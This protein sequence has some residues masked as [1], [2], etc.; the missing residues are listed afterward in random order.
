MRSYFARFSYDRLDDVNF[1]RSGQSLSTEWRGERTGL[2]SGQLT[3]DAHNDSRIFNFTETALHVVVTGLTL[4]RGVTTANNFDPDSDTTF[5]GGALRFGSF[6]ELALTDVVISDSNTYGSHT[7]GGGMYVAG[8]LTMIS[9]AVLNCSTNFHNGDGGGIWVGLDATFDDCEIR[10]NTAGGI[11]SDGGGISASSLVTITNSVIADNSSVD[12]GGGVWSYS[13]VTIIGSTISGNSTTM[14]KTQAGGV[15]GRNVTVVSSTIYGN[16]AFDQGGG[17]IWAYDDV[18]VIGSTVSGNSTG[19]GD[20]SEGGGIWADRDLIIAFSTI[21][22]NSSGGNGGGIRGGRRATSISNS[23]V[24]GNTSVLGTH[25]IIRLSPHS[26]SVLY[27][28]VGDNTGTSLAE[29]Q[30]TDPNG[31]RIGSSTGAGVINPKLGPLADNGGALLTHALLPGSPAIDAGDPAPVDPPIWDVRA[32][33]FER[34]RDGNGDLAVR[35]DMGAFEVQTPF[36]PSADFTGDGVVDGADFLAWQRGFGL[37]GTALPINGDANGDLVVDGADLAFWCETFESPEEED[38]DDA[39]A[40][41]IAASSD[42]GYTADGESREPWRDEFD[43]AMQE[44]AISFALNAPA[45]DLRMKSAFLTP[46][47]ESLLAQEDEG[48]GSDVQQQTL[49]SNQAVADAA[50]SHGS[51]VPESELLKA[52]ED[53]AFGVGFEAAALNEG[54]EADQVGFDALASFAL[55]VETLQ[56]A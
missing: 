6:G 15:G 5:S 14:P 29:S 17:G 47:P 34:L 28:I 18:T 42:G 11:N 2:G 24:A 1:P 51:P 31:S 21:T 16:S 37:S 20:L 50:P 32:V 54:S 52:I 45:A 27:S 33:G 4:R 19:V 25:D 38:L 49:F 7:R 48:N 12:D 13:N 8:S 41:S 35:A 46:I 30:L 9:S 44:L 43:A 56:F 39:I 53:G 40:H 3:I 26:F 23:I 55:S 22:G 36:V 10:G